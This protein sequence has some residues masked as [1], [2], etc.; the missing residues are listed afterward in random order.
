MENRTGDW[1][2]RLLDKDR[3][4]VGTPLKSSLFGK[5]FGFEELE[6]RMLKCGEQ[7]KQQGFQERTRSAIACVVKNSGSETDLPG[8]AEGY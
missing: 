7:I 5:S 8:K 1:C 6:K 2:I 4:N 3:N